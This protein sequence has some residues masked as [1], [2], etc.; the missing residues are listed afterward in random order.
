MMDFFVREV[1]A[2][3]DG[4]I[5]IIRYGTCGGKHLNVLVALFALNCG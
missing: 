4:P 5:A 1:R 3:V 2:I